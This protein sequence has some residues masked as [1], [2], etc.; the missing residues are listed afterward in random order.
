M[1][2]Y[3]VATVVKPIFRVAL[4]YPIGG[5]LDDG[6]QGLAGASLSHPQ[7]RFKFAEGQFDGV[8]IGRV[9]WQIQQA[10]A[11]RSRKSRE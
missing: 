10:G 6:F 9:G 8:E 4:G 2:V 11:T 7:P 3:V 1:S 5:V